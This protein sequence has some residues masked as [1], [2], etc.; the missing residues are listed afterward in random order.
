LAALGISFDGTSAIHLAY[1]FRAVSRTCTGLEA[2]SLAL[3][4]APMP[5]MST[6]SAYKHQ[7]IY[8]CDDVLR[9]VSPLRCT[10][11]AVDA[12]PATVNIRSPHNS[13]SKP[14]QP[15]TRH[16]SSS[17]THSHA[18]SSAFSAT[19]SHA[20]PFRSRPP[21]VKARPCVVELWHCPCQPCLHTRLLGW[22]PQHILMVLTTF[23]RCSLCDIVSKS[24]AAV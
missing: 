18:T 1:V 20:R 19:P 22:L 2:E 16:Y 8:V 3:G 12:L 6:H 21:S 15:N 9:R 11:T 4:S 14:T 24:K 23:D 5:C 17:P 10:L 7:E 13:D